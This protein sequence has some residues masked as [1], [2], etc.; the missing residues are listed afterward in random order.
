MGSRIR[1]MLPPSHRRKRK[2]KRE[3]CHRGNSPPLPGVGDCLAFRSAGLT[4]PGGH[5]A[6]QRD[7]RAHRVHCDE[8]GAQVVEDSGGVQ[9]ERL[10]FPA[11]W[12]EEACRRTQ[13]GEEA[14][15]AHL[16][17]III[18]VESAH[19]HTSIE[20]TQKCAQKQIRPS[21]TTTGKRR[22]P[23]PYDMAAGCSEG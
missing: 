17:D 2:N 14:G 7:H 12:K 9:S 18:Q 1:A 21:T 19:P 23:C 16:P 6:P 13:S 8:G 15:S 11:I 10:G 20:K 3:G 5:Q 4:E 22:T